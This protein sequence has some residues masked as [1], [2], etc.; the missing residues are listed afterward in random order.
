MANKP[1]FQLF[2]PSITVSKKLIWSGVFTFSLSRALSVSRCV[3]HPAV[4]GWYGSIHTVRH[5]IYD[6]NF[7]FFCFL[8]LV[9]NVW[10]RSSVKW[11]S[12]YLCQEGR[13]LR[14]HM[15]KFKHDNKFFFNYYF[16]Q[17]LHRHVNDKHSVL[18]G[19]FPRTFFLSLLWTM[20]YWLE[21]YSY[22]YHGL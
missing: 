16:L 18:P 15:I 1:E 14:W 8:S 21:S 3:K 22:L 5:Q 20:Y 9:Y 17:L 2:C 7:W 12:P 10:I 6:G 11:T 13:L 19:V 4:I